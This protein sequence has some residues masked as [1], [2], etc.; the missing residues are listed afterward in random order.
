MSVILNEYRDNIDRTWYDSSNVLYSE[1]LDKQDD[2]KDLTIVFKGGRC[3]LY[4]NI[5]VN[6]YILFRSDISQGKALNKYIQVKDVKGNPK[7]ETIRLPDVDLENLE[8]EKQ[9]VIESR[10]IKEPE[11]NSM[12]RIEYDKT[13]G[14]SRLYFNEKLIID[15]TEG[16][17][18]LFEIL[19]ALNIFAT[20]SN[21]KIDVIS[22]SYESVACLNSDGNVKE[23]AVYKDK[24][25]VFDSTI[26]KITYQDDDTFNT[27]L[28][29]E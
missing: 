7:Y 13:N 27:I 10:T 15:G 28:D 16:H 24:Q 6:D 4:K 17:Y 20:I 26:G 29:N 11:N 3:Y 12:Y 9:L 14:R 8:K 1:C 2:Y 5:D 21:E 19:V 25:L 22:P 18:N 23:Y